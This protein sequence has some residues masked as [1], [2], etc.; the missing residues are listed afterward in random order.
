MDPAICNSTSIL[1]QFYIADYRLGSKNFIHCLSWGIF[2]EKAMPNERW[3]CQRCWKTQAAQPFY[4]FRW[5]QNWKL[6]TKKGECS[7]EMNNVCDRKKWKRRIE[8][9]PIKAQ[10]KTRR[11]KN[12]RGLSHRFPP[13]LRGLQGQ[14]GLFCFGLVL[15]FFFWS[16]MSR[17]WVLS[18]CFLLFAGL[19][20]SFKIRMA[21]V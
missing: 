20:T 16:F 15:G 5:I 19:S 11:R 12:V 8:P 6:Q 7:E 4:F 17:E 13:H 10:R 14:Q 9:T 18:L 1:S 21:A 3:K 2:Q